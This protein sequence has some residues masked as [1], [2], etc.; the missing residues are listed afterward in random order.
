MSP[1]YWGIV[2]GL[3]AMVA[4][5]LLCLQIVSRNTVQGG[6]PEPGSAE[7]QDQAAD[8]AGQGSKHAA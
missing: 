8:A 7:P 2:V 6:T 5:L 4:L 3:F 1:V